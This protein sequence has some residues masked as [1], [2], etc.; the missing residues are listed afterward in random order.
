MMRIRTIHWW[1]AALPILVTCGF[2]QTTEDDAPRSDVAGQPSETAT[3]SE[4]ADAAGNADVVISPS[5]DD[6][7]GIEKRNEAL[8]ARL[9]DEELARQALKTE[10][11]K[12]EPTMIAEPSPA[13]V[14]PEPT[15]PVADIPAETAPRSSMEEFQARVAEFEP[16]MNEIARTADLLDDNYRRYID[17]CYQKYTS[18]ESSGSFSGRARGYSQGAATGRDWFAV[19]TEESR[20][21]F[22]GTYSESTSISNES[23]A[24]CRELWSDIL[25]GSREV[26]QSMKALQQDARR[27]GVLPG[28]LRDLRRRFRLDWEGWTR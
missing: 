2:N 9:R 22:E 17:A 10:R 15:L 8:L 3:A 16:R 11:E 20:M 25:D 24:Y 18:A 28:H 14:I 19:Y 12:A 7:K 6:G 5:T 26:N 21:A 27:K 1:L 4:F 13:T 23:T